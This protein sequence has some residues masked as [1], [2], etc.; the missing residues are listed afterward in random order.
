[1][2]KENLKLLVKGLKTLTQD[3]FDMKEF[4]NKCGTVGC[5]VGWATT[6]KGLEPIDDDMVESNEIDYVSYSRRVFKLNFT[7][8]DWCFDSDWTDIDSTIDGA[9][10]RINYLVENTG[11]PESFK[12][13]YQFKDQY[14]EMFYNKDDIII[15]NEENIVSDDNYFSITE[16]A[17]N[18]PEQPWIA[19]D[20]VACFAIPCDGDFSIMSMYDAMAFVSSNGIAS[21]IALRIPKKE[22]DKCMGQEEYSLKIK[23]E[24]FVDYQGSVL[25]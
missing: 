24:Y 21:M 19:C 12:S 25:I 7:E 16:N 1:M 14:N 3:Q 5:V 18:Y 11:K 20:D 4:M 13:A 6:F 2:H 23:D 22:Y 15:T 9:I 17:K 10:K 8:W